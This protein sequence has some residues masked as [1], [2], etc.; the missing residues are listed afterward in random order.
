MSF[1]QAGS[2]DPTF[3]SGGK[4]VTNFFDTFSSSGVEGT[5][6]QS[7]GKIAAVGSLPNGSGIY[8]YNRDGSPD[9]EFGDSG[10]IFIYSLNV[11]CLA[12][13]S[14]GKFVVAGTIKT[15]VGGSTIKIARYNSDG[16]L[17]SSF[18]GEW[19][20]IPQVG[21]SFFAYSI[22]IQTDGK[23]VVAGDRASGLFP[24]Y[25]D[26]LVARYNADGSLDNNFG[27][28]GVVFTDFG[29]IL[30][31][32]KSVAVQADGKI[33]VA[34]GG[35]V[36]PYIFTGPSAGSHFAMVRYNPD[37]SLD[38]S[39][40][41]DGMLLTDLGTSPS[42]ANSIAIQADDKIVLAGTGAGGFSVVRY[43]TDGSLD[44]S[45]DN[46][47]I[48]VANMGIS[49]SASSIA[50]QADG[51]IIAGG[52]STNGTK[53][54]FAGIRI[55]R[56][57][58]LDDSFDGDGRLIT[59][60]GFSSFVHSA[61]LQND[62]RII[63]AGESQEAQSR[64]IT[65][66]ARYN[67]D[68][69]LDNNFDG[70]GILSKSLDYSIEFANAVAVQTDGRIVVAGS[71]DMGETSGDFAI[72]RYNTD[73]SL[74]NSFDV[75]GKLATDIDSFYDV[76]YAVAVQADGKIIVAGNG[77]TGNEIIVALA[78]YNSD[79][80]IDAS[81]DGDGKLSTDFI[82]SPAGAIV[83]SVTPQTDGKILVGGS[84][85]DHFIIA[86]YNT[87]GSADTGFD[88]DGKLTTIFSNNQAPTWDYPAVSNAI[89]VQAD[90]KI[91]VVGNAGVDGFAVARYNYDGSPDN[92][93]DGDG[94]LITDIGPSRDAAYTQAVQADG[95]ILVAGVSFNETHYDFAMIRYN[96][97]G[98]LDNSF[99]AD[100]KLTT[101]AGFSCDVHSIA[102]QADGRIVLAGNS[103]DRK[104]Q[105][106]VLIRYNTDGSIDETFG[107]DGKIVI[108]DFPVR[109]E[110]WNAMK[111]FGNRIYFA[112]YTITKT[113]KDFL[114][115]A[116][117]VQSTA[118]VSCPLDK[119]VQAEPSQC[120]A[121]VNDI[122]P[123]ITPAGNNVIV[124]YTLSGATS[125]N[126]TGSASGQSFNKGVTT[127]TYSIA[128]E[129]EKTCSFTVTVKPSPEICNNGKDDDCDGLID[130][131]CRKLPKIYITNTAVREGNSG[132]RNANFELSLSKPGDKPITVEYHT[133]DRTAQ[134]PG[135]Y[136]QKSGTVTFPPGTRT[137]R[138]LIKVKG[139]R[140]HEAN[141]RFSVV[142]SDAVNGLIRDDRAVCTIIDDDPV[143]AINIHD[144]VTKENCG[145]VL[146]RVSLNESS[147]QVITVRYFTKNGS[148]QAPGDYTA[149]SNGILVF[150][151]GETTKNIS[152]VINQ[153]AQCE[154][155]EKFYVL[156]RQAENAELNC[157]EAE[158]RIINSDPENRLM[159]KG[160]AVAQSA[161]D[162]SRM[163]VSP[164]PANQ[165]VN[166]RLF[167]KM[168]S[169]KIV[170]EL[171]D[172]NGRIVKQ[173]IRSYD[174]DGQSMNL[175]VADIPGGVYLVVIKDGKGK[176]LQ[177]QVV[178]QH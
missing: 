62:G 58:S 176:R 168:V 103:A 36:T 80:S 48:L 41:D 27:E 15:E 49:S 65:V 130:E 21:L 43:N 79:G 76:A 83:S 118:Q 153:D 178:V 131:D 134:A 91:I 122:D 169:G 56:D 126:G 60:A 69:S 160:A 139:D 31:Y 92:S 1:S 161:T 137:K 152:I 68:G 55:N 86:R 142:L 61:I 104:I 144:A 57:G 73:G 35:S 71:C 87:D 45:F 167:N 157:K 163:I 59:D 96:A 111:I 125:T 23:I 158:V 112:G 90:G 50:I 171:M 136:E 148:A 37:G 147:D 100:G 52:S 66:I 12:I 40:D 154:P 28:D 123:V 51:K 109:P 77:N 95:K 16:R 166:L 47:G 117:L 20:I 24:P 128:G 6:V 146:V 138:I 145:Q 165:S 17:D 156:L 159:T 98:S 13:Q 26:F 38:S 53:S 172:Q 72:A 110:Y 29:S 22:A 81:F 121:V 150:E 113:D 2:L 94:K 101:N 3:G 132:T 42:S 33:V 4:I 63:M 127:V 34:G 8:R 106:S 93:F 174:S 44:N 164:N 114:L 82:I 175:P 67:T 32:G 7:D 105:K 149:I 99:D 75:D 78:R 108:S 115:A 84:N 124:N 116:Y 129:P 85:S 11:N 140:L 19:K 88:G 120:Q 9:N 14:D 74:D 5:A 162:E 64:T 143:P 119:T 155:T 97:D 10:L 70:D 102:I 25:H 18:N 107:L 135:D 30:D 46:D 54:F 170:V 133:T 39:F 151:P 173:W 177:Q 141:E 89:A